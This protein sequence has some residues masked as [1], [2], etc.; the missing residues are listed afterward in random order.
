VQDTLDLRDW[1]YKCTITE[2]VLNWNRQESIAKK[3]RYLDGHDIM[4]EF[5]LTESPIVGYL[6][7]LLDEAVA[8]GTVRSREQALLYLGEVQVKL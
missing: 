7:A 8:L 3:A 5:L 4:H 6:L 2:Q 1:E